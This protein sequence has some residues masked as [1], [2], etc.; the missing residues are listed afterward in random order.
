[1]LIPI[2]EFLTVYRNLADKH[3]IQRF[4][5]LHALVKCGIVKIN[6]LCAFEHFTDGEIHLSK[7]VG[8]A[9]LVIGDLKN[10]GV[11]VDGHD[12]SRQCV[13]FVLQ[14]V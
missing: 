3:C 5:C 11:E 2:R 7:D 12:T 8:I 6:R 4:E 14:E 10:R 13:I 9:F 1:M